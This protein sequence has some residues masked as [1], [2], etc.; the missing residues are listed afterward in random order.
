MKIFFTI[1]LFCLA[2]SGCATPKYTATPIHEKISEKIVII[3]DRDTR[4]GFQDAV[5]GWVEKIIMNMLLFRTA[6]NMI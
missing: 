2:L 1:L 6:Q 3:N 4:V 5:K